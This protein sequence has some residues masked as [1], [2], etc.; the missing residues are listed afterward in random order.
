MGQRGVNPKAWF[1]GFGSHLRKNAGHVR[2]ALA[3]SAA[4]QWLNMELN[5]YLLTRLPKGLYAYPEA[6]KRDVSVF[7][8]SPEQHQ[9][10]HSYAAV[11]ETKAIY[12]QYSQSRIERMVSVMTRQLEDAERECD[13]GCRTMGLVMGVW[14]DWDNKSRP[15]RAASPRRETLS[16]FRRIA[17]AAVRKAAD[18]KGF[19]PQKETMETMVP[20]GV[21]TVGP[22]SVRV[23]LVGQY[24]MR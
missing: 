5:A 6:S 15:R 13:E 21:V 22:W 20:E 7:S 16:G 18:A 8:F 17:G 9:D 1:Y 3:G 4:E 23:A 24:F 10:E 11:I 14:S 19:P 2:R 12:R